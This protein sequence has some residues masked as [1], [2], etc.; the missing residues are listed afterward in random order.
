MAARKKLEAELEELK[1]QTAAAG[2]GKEDA[3]KQ[4]RKMQVRR[5]GPA[6]SGMRPTLACLL[7]HQC[8]RSA[9]PP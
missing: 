2:Q 3:V 5:G 6:R 9:A 7:H 4:L 1:A 8:T